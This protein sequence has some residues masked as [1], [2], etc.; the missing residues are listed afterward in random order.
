MVTGRIV[1]WA[2]LTVLVL[3]CSMAVPASGSAACVNDADAVQRAGNF[4][5]NP[6]SL[7]TS[8]DISSDVRDFVAANP[9]ALGAV[10]EL[11][12]NLM[13]DPGTSDKQS[14]IGKGLGL[15]AGLCIRPD[16][17]FAAEIQT[18]LAGVGSDVA[19]T[20]YAK[21]TGNAPIRAVAA[22][23]LG[24]G[25]STGSVG[26]Q[27]TPLSTSGGSV[28]FQTFTANSVSNNSS[29][30]FSGGVSG[31]GAAGSNTTTTTTTTT[32]VCAVSTTC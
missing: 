9:Q 30:F 22:G 6:S 13:K 27:T 7:L 21:I 14:A 5:T 11:L 2:K 32:I 8:G 28:G 26:G 19:N 25:A 10:V 15:A 20:E 17:T 24:A 31:A 18:Q 3:L 1:A 12:K 29:N 23:G 4:L 16:P